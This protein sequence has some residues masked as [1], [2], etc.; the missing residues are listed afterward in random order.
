MQ[1]ELV[2]PDVCKPLCPGQQQA[3]MDICGIVAL[4]KECRRGRV[5]LNVVEF[6][7]RSPQAGDWGQRGAEPL[8]YVSRYHLK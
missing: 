2:V 5:G 7:Q 8:S 1:V 4:E 3:S 6:S